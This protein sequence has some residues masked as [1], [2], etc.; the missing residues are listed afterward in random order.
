MEEFKS[1]FTKRWFLY[2]LLLFVVWYVGTLFIFS[3][4]EVT[5]SDVAYVGF[6]LYQPMA[7]FLVSYFYFRKARNT[8]NDRLVTA[9]LWVL[10]TY[11]LAVLLVEPVYGY[12]MS[13]V[14]NWHSF[15][16]NWINLAAIIFAG[17]VAPH[18]QNI[19]SAEEKQKILSDIKA[20]PK[21]VAATV[22]LKSTK[23]PK[24]PT[25]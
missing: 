15:Q 5:N 22:A 17:F 19:L 7:V 23:K 13:T 12:D 10:V 3:W 8:W 20:A 25:K 11:I 14:L 9:V 24:T 6:Q 16:S 18:A 21:K 4:Y 1:Y 2:Y